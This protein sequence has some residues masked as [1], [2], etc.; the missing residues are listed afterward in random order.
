MT[1]GTQSRI[2]LVDDEEPIGQVL[3]AGLEMHGFT[4]RYEPRPT[5]AIKACLDFHPDLV[6]LDIDMP[7]KDGGEV[8]ADLQADS[9]LRNIPVIFL[10][11]LVV[12]EE[13]GKRNASRELLLSKQLRVTELVTILR[14]VL[15]TSRSKAG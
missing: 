10:S 7:G 3:K 1:T 11:S 15:R 13:T 2:L 5:N 8:A 9:T 12:K 4:V 14:E 6:L